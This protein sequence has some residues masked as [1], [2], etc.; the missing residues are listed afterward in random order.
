ML[1]NYHPEM[2]PIV[3]VWGKAE[4]F[5]RQNCAYSLPALREMIPRCLGQEGVSDELVLKFFERVDRIQNAYIERKLLYGTAAF[6]DK[7]HKSHRRVA[8]EA[9]DGI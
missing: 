4:K 8:T 1:L 3:Y 5:S 2:N 9:V 6:K 7:V